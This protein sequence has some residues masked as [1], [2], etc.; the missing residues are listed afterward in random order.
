MNDFQQAAPATAQNA[1]LPSESHHTPDLEHPEE[2][3]NNEQ[4]A[5]A[6]GSHS[7]LVPQTDLEVPPLFAPL[8]LHYG[9]SLSK[10]DVRRVIEGFR[11]QLSVLDGQYDIELATMENIGEANWTKEDSARAA[12]I[13]RFYKGHRLQTES[14][15]KALKE[16]SLRTS[17]L[18]DGSAN[19]LKDYCEARENR[20]EAIEKIEIRRLAAERDALAAQRL[21]ELAPYKVEDFLMPFDLGSISEEQ[22]QVLFSGMKSTFE[23]KQ[24]EMRKEEEERK[25]KEEAAAKRLDRVNQLSALGFQWR[26]DLNAYTFDSLRVEAGVLEFGGNTWQT[27]INELSA[28]VGTINATKAEQAAT[29]RE[30]ARIAGEQLAEIEREKAEAVEAERLAALAPD[31]EKVILYFQSVH[32]AVM[33]MPEVENEDMKALLQRHFDAVATITNQYAAEASKLGG[34]VEVHDLR[35]QPEDAGCPF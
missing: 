10:E 18:I 23:A 29:D 7:A 26:V 16:K 2:T 35:D 13:R 19:A 33:A 22:Y 17:Q 27:L 8:A 25:A 3:A 6:P 5:D 11:G 9:R 15:R 21:A 28:Q 4:I 14:T 1:D 20:A 12:D 34:N 24:A 30:N 31:K 32:D